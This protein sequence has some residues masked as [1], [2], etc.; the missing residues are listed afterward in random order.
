MTV[1]DRNWQ[2]LRCEKAVLTLVASG[3]VR[4]LD[5]LRDF[6]SNTYFWY[7][8]Q[9]HNPAR[10]DRVLATADRAL[11]WLVDAGFVEQDDEAFLVTPLG[12]ATAWSGLLPTT[13]KAFVALLN[14]RAT[15]IEGH[16]DELA[17]G[18]VHWICCSDEFRGETPSRFLPFPIGGASLGSTTFVA[19]RPL[20][21][22]LDRTDSQMCQSVHALIL[23]I[24]GAEER[25][26][27]RRTK[28]SSGSVYRLAADVG[29]I[30]DGLRTIAAVPDISCPQ[31][32]GNALGLMARRVRWGFSSRNT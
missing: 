6:F 11:G 13:A 22:P 16:F 12:Q 20:L 28:M 3:G 15:D 21:W 5:E 31:T 10:L 25:I 19:G 27:F 18:L 14:E 2:N 32:V 26:I 17:G 7:L 1:S 9:E 23:F 4:T 30:L 29:W 24:E 8:L